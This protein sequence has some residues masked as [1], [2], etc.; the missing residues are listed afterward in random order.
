MIRDSIKTVIYVV[1]CCHWLMVS[2]SFFLVLMC[3]TF[4]FAFSVLCN[5]IKTVNCVIV[6]PLIN[7]QCFMLWVW[8][9]WKCYVTCAA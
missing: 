1:W 6:L 8:M 9:S 4:F 3:V 7:A 5:S 2:I